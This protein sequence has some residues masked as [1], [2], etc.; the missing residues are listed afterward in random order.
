ME[1]RYPGVEVT[2]TTYPVPSMKQAAAR[3]VWAGQAIGVALVLF[4]HRI[5]PAVGVVVA[6]DVLVRLQQSKFAAITGIWLVGNTV[7]NALMSTGAFE[8][9]CDGKL[10][11]SKLAQ[12]RMPQ[13][14]E[15]FGSLDTCMEA[16][17][18]HFTA[19]V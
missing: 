15:V 18:S 2:G 14:R 11:F 10:I 12:E 3:L 17:H 5:L 1:Q 19:A 6:P 16:F 7:V 13:L 4:G 8:I 9:F